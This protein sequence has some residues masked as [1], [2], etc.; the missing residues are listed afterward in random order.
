MKLYLFIAEH[1]QREKEYHKKL[2]E[3][4]KKEK[5]DIQTEENLFERLDELELQEELADEIN[6]SLYY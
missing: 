6:R 3:L 4:R 1:R 2:S 5:T